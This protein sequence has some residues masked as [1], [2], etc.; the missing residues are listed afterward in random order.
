MDLDAIES[1]EAQSIVETSASATLSPLAPLPPFAALPPLAALPSSATLPPP[2]PLPSSATLPPP[3]PVAPP[4]PSTVSPTQTLRPATAARLASTLRSL[5]PLW[6]LPDLDGFAGAPARRAEPLAFFRRGARRARAARAAGAVTRSQPRLPSWRARL[7]RALVAPL[8]ALLLVVVALVEVESTVSAPGALLAP[9]GSASAQSLLPGVV[10]EVLAREGDR[11]EAGQAIARLDDAALRASLALDERQL[12]VARGESEEASRADREALD[13][14]LGALRRQRAALRERAR[15]QQTILQRRRVRLEDV[16]A[17][18]DFGLARPDDARAA[19]DAIQGAAAQV[20]LLDYQLVELEL[21]QADRMR[22]GQTRE[23]ER[24]T[25]LSR[26]TAEVDAARSRL[27]SAVIRAPASGRVESLHA[28]V[29]EVVAPGEVIARVVPQH[30]PRAVVAYLPLRQAAFIRVGTEASV[31]L[32]S[33]P[34]DELGVARARVARV[35]SD[36][37]PQAEVRSTGGREPSGA[38]VRVELELVDDAER[39]ALASRLRSG[40]RVRVCW[41]RRGR[42]LGVALELARTWLDP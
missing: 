19:G 22:D 10:R 27:A 12:E 24:R 8:A 23:R 39:E 11:V 33:L 36:V 42:A 38:H 7:A 25:L 9:A 31:E 41:H 29:G 16:R 2:A 34:G 4:L 5:P 13:Q 20:A 17:R 3:A 14:A 32:D 30:A 26:L 15:I 21:M 37:A 40:E 28:P 6:A 18:V 35:S 1:V